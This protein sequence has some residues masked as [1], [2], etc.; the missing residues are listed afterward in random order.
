MSPSSLKFEVIYFEERASSLLWLLFFSRARRIDSADDSPP[1]AR[2]EGSAFSV[3]GR[4]HGRGKE[5]VLVAGCSA[6]SGVFSR[7][8][9]MFGRGQHAILYSL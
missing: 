4:G 5:C 8:Q 2:F 9:S 3:I 1:I 7:Q 6:P